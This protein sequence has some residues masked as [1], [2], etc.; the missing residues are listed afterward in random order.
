MEN[1]PGARC[2]GERY[3][4]AVKRQE[5]LILFTYGDMN[6]FSRHV[7]LQRAWGVDA[8]ICDNVGDLAR[9]RGK[10]QSLFKREHD[11]HVREAAAARPG[12][13][14]DNGDGGGGSS[15]RHAA[16]GGVIAEEDEGEG[17]RDRRMR[18]EMREENARAAKTVAKRALFGK[19]GALGALRPLGRRGSRRRRAAT[20]AGEAITRASGG[21]E[22]VAPF[23]A[24]CVCASLAV[25]ACVLA[26]AY[27]RARKQ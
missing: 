6:S 20:A 27:L 2:V 5:G 7:D 15:P 3:V 17:A 13:W 26:V 21:R 18:K 8:V 23:A 19:D 14:Y 22:W 25:G 11:R 24:G 10:Y 12:H 1:D 9:A 16:E 4:D